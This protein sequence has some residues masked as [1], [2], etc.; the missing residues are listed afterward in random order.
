MKE[1]TSQGGHA[2]EI[3]IKKDMEMLHG[4]IAAIVIFSSFMILLRQN[5]R[6]VMEKE[7]EIKYREQL[8]SILANNTEDVFVML[9]T[10]DHAVEYISPNVERV[11]GILPEEVKADLSVPDREGRNVEEFEYYEEML[12]M[13]PGSSFTTETERVHKK[14]GEHLWFMETIYRV[15]IDNADKFIASLSD[16]TLEKQ[17]E[18]ALEQALEIAKAANKSKSTFLNN[19]S[20]DIRTPMNAIVGL[21]T[22]L[23]RDADNPALVRDHTRKIT[24]S[25]QHLLGLINDVLDMSKIESGRTTLNI[26]EINLAEI[27]DELGTIIRPQARAKKQ[28]FDIF[29]G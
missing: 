26:T 6:N 17:K 12:Q 1:V 7:M 4:L 27:V 14:T 24:A 5:R 15:T 8:F 13:E 9:T 25:S 19:M 3:Y 21:C 18:Q 29:R 10:W 16:R 11:L 2:F 23:Q 22:L 20:H 28:S